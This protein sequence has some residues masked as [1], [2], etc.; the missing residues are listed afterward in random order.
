MFRIC[1][2]GQEQIAAIISWAKLKKG[3]HRS[4][5][6]L[7][8]NQN[9]VEIKPDNGRESTVFEP[10]FPLMPIA[11]SGAMPNT[12]ASWNHTVYTLLPFSAILQSCSSTGMARITDVSPFMWQA[13]KHSTR[14]GKKKPTTK[15]GAG[16]FSAKSQLWLLLV[17]TWCRLRNHSGKTKDLSWALGSSIWE[18]KRRQ[19]SNYLIL[20][21]QFV[22]RR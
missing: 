3:S 1:Q 20:M 22:T 16:F 9:V 4:R 10:E 11:S 2:D 21:L 17:F 13:L 12:T 14:S 5:V 7:T 19:K 8:I 15:W 6:G 18:V